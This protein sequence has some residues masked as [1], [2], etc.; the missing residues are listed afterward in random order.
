MLLEMSR[1]DRSSPTIPPSP[2]IGK[3]IMTYVKATAAQTPPLRAASKLVISTDPAENTW[4]DLAPGLYPGEVVVQLTDMPTPRPFI[5]LSYDPRRL[6]NGGGVSIFAW[7]RWCEIVDPIKGQTKLDKHGQHLETSI[8][9]TFSPSERQTY[10]T[11]ALG[12][13]L[14]LLCAGEPLTLMKTIPAQ[15]G[16]TQQVPVVNVSAE[17]KANCSIREAIAASAETGPAEDAATALG[18]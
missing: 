5:A 7:A 2:K 9:F 15:G 18:I 13:E 6:E 10:G 4:D 16:G 1:V 12:K 17:V 8:S 14:M 11:R 3:R